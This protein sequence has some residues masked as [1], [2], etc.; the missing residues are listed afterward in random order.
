MALL[1][2]IVGMITAVVA[3]PPASAHGNPYER[4]PDPTVESVA[5]ERGTFAT[6]ELDVE[7]SHGFN[8]WKIYYPKDTG[9]GTW[10]V[11]AVVPGYT[12][13]WK[14]EGAWMGHWIASFGFVVVGIDTNSPTDRDDARG[15]QLLA[16]L[17][18][19]TE[20]SPVAGRVDPDRLGV[21]GH[22][23][24][25]GGAIHAATQRPELQAAV[26]FAPASFSQDLSGVKVPTMV[27]DLGAGHHA[28][29][30]FDEPTSRAAPCRRH[31]P[32]CRCAPKNHP[33]PSPVISRWAARTGH[34][35]P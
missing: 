5:A 14:D 9:L 18:Y 6:D 27:I 10:G 13:S 24:G 28:D 20:E 8:G 4:G 12:A 29:F 2:A 1:A 34:P 35:C 33:F 11:A 30:L 16:A 7:P 26:L 31:L 22:S 32:C 19:L 23:M 21:M 25:G 17:D 3:M 15:R